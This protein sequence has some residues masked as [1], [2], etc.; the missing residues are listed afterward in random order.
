MRQVNFSGPHRQQGMSKWGWL[1]T[2]IAVGFVITSALRLGPHYIDYRLIQGVAQDLHGQNMHTKMSRRQ[3]EE[4]FQKQLRINNFR[5][6]IKELLSVDRDSEQT[7]V[8]INYEI[9]EH[10]FYNID[11]VLVFSDQ[12]TYR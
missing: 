1:F 7:L 6:P 4:H 12:F 10:L 9:R 8:N 3:I 5:I 2:A 11:V